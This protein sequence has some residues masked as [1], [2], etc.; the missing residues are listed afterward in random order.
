MALIFNFCSLG[1][2]IICFEVFLRYFRHKEEAIKSTKDFYLAFFFVGLGYI[3]LSLPE[4]ILFDPFWIQIAF[5]LQD[6]SFLISML[7]FGPATLGMFK[8]WSGFQ[9]IISLIVLLWLGLYIILNTI[10]FSPAVPLKIDG[11]I[12]FWQSG[13][14][15]VQSMGRILLVVIALMISILFF[16]GAK[17][18]LSQ[19]RLFWRC[20][21]GALGSIMIITAGFILWFA[22]F[23]Y[24]SPSLLVFSGI[25]GLLGFVVG[26]I[27]IGWIGGVVL[28]PFR[29]KFVK[30]IT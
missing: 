14:F 1:A 20:F 24:F 3:F 19:K 4:L 25:L 29:K 26:W 10:F 11:I 2:T 23:F 13:S 17:K 9:K 12:Y 21:F 6:I 16:I 28:K 18:V 30:K 7:F 5:I 27:G 15:W 8:K 22:S